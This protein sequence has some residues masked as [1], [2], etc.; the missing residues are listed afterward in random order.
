M[1]M[2]MNI[3]NHLNNKFMNFNKKLNMIYFMNPTIYLN[4]LN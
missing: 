3:A 1:N 2:I 4:Y